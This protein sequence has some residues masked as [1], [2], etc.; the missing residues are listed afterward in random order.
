MCIRDSPW[1]AVR[2]RWFLLIPLFI[3]IYLLFSGRTPL[4]SGTVGLALTAM[5]IL[6]SA[7]ILRVSSKV[8]RFA[9]WIALG[10]LCAGFFQLGIG[11][12]FGV[13][14]ALV[15][16]CWFVK[17]GRETLTLCLHALVEG[18]LLYTSRCV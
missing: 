4:F 14:A 1:K 18:G 16:V 6:G 17:G 3:L 9:F 8:M 11:V 12:V 7:I 10:V 2:E 5:V 13:I 15:A